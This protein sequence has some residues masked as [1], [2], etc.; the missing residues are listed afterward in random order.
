MIKK[1]LTILRNL[2]KRDDLYIS[3]PDKGNSVVILNRSDYGNDMLDILS[4]NTKFIPVNDDCYKL[5]QGLEAHLNN[6]L[7][8]LFKSSKIDKITYNNLQAIG[9]GPGKLYGL[10]SV[11]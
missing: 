1:L 10:S 6:V 4:D 8:A 2:G 3:K 7:L 9:S 5:S 11:L